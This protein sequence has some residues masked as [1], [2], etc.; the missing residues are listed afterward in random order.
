MRGSAGMLSGLAEAHTFRKR[1][2]MIG[3][4]ISPAWD[5]TDLVGN[6]RTRES[7]C[8]LS[9]GSRYENLIVRK[10]QTRLHL[11]E[12]LRRSLKVIG[13]KGLV[14]GTSF[15]RT[16]GYF[17]AL[18]AFCSRNRRTLARFPQSFI[19]HQCRLWLRVRS[20]NIHPQFSPAQRRRRS[21]S[22][23]VTKSAAD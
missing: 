21:R 20:R 8:Y 6:S 12:V 13:T 5:S 2:R 18:S 22:G 14:T 7:T 11:A 1:S 17:C 10:A 23:E 19:S 9:I 16:R 15:A 4:S 3:S